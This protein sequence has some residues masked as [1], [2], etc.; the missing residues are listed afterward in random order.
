MNTIHDYLAGTESAM[1]LL[2]QGIQSYTDM[3]GGIPV[4]VTGDPDPE[5]EAWKQW[6]RDNA[7]AIAASMD[8]Q[9]QFS[10]SAFAM[11][12]LCGT[13]LQV[14]DKAIELYSANTAL[15]SSADGILV[16]GKKTAVPYCI[17]H[18]IRGVPIGLIIYAGRNQHAHFEEDPKAIGRAV[19]A[20]LAHPE[21]GYDP[22]F[23]LQ[24]PR[25]TNYAHNI[26]GLLKWRSYAAYLADMQQLPLTKTYGDAP[27]AIAPEIS[28]TA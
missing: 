14:A 4:F 17:G 21:G 26:T 23:D 11:A 1:R 16:P 25:L 8:R 2:F 3:I 18:E 15:T 5:S 22:A 27:S 20:R 12:T 19:F 7:E 13:V 9:R 24:N 28:P 10:V 6:R